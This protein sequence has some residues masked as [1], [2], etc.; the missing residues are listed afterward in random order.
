MSESGARAA[1]HL[2]RRL[3][4][5]GQNLQLTDQ[6]YYLRRVK[7]EFRRNRQ[8][9]DPVQIDFHLK[10]HFRAIIFQKVLNNFHF[11][12]GEALLTNHRII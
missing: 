4:R 1:L 11:Q 5:Y 8:L 9:T 3:L 10:V 6:T 2:Y 12:K 7:G